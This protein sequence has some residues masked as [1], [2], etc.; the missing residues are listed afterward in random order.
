MIFYSILRTHR[1]PLQ[2]IAFKWRKIELVGPLC[3]VSSAVLM[4][5]EVARCNGLYM[6]FG[7]YVSLNCFLCGLIL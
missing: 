6:A 1:W 4:A 5:V 2:S 7:R 3:L